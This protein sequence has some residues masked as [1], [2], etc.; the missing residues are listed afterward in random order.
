MTLLGTA[1]QAQ[2]GEPKIT[3]RDTLAIV[4]VYYNEQPLAEQD[5]PWRNFVDDAVQL[6]LGAYQYKKISLITCDHN[7]YNLRFHSSYNYYQY[8]V[9]SKCG[10]PNTLTIQQYEDIVIDGRHCNRIYKMDNYAIYAVSGLNPIEAG[11]TSMKEP[12]NNRNSLYTSDRYGT[13][14]SG[15][16]LSGRGAKVLPSPKGG[17]Q[18]Q[19]KIVVKIRVDREGNVVSVE[20]PEKGSTIRDADIVSLAKEAAMKAKFSAKEDAPETQ[21]GTITYVLRNN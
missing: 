6:D 7:C 8:K 9:V 21:V 11:K 1:A 17:T 20:A 19:G 18:K 10:K 5:W 2:L 3:V 14:S 12:E 4:A 16:S 15:F 13:P